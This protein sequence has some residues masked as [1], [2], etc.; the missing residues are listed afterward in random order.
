MSKV[1]SGGLMFAKSKIKSGSKFF[2]GNMR[3]KSQRSFIGSEN[4]SKYTGSRSPSMTVGESPSRIS[5]ESSN[6]MQ[7]FEFIN[8]ALPKKTF[9]APTQR[10]REFICKHFLSKSL[11]EYERMNFQS[12]TMNTFILMANLSECIDK[13]LSI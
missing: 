4:N 5:E 9:K 2:S 7:S 10:L 1:G 12:I 8:A 6:S 3:K 11:E 13:I